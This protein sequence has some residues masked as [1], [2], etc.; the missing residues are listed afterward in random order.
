MEL[1]LCRN[2]RSGFLCQIINVYLINNFCLWSEL[3]KMLGFL[4]Q[5][6]SSGLSVKCRVTSVSCGA[7]EEGSWLLI[8]VI[9]FRCFDSHSLWFALIA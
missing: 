8:Q 9:R 6:M 7:L 3:A 5:A 4:K 2:L 1:K